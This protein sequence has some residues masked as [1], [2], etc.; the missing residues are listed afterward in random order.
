MPT[1]T[2]KLSHPSRGFGYI[3]QESGGKDVFVHNIHDLD[4]RI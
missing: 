2:V 4:S 3:Q 1:E